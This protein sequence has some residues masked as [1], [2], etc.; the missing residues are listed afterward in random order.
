MVDWN[1]STVAIPA[2]LTQG[3]D[4]ST[5]VVELDSAVGYPPTPFTVVLSPR[6]ATE[7]VVTVTNTSGTT[8]TVNRGQ[9]GTAALPHSA[10]AGVEHKVTARDHQWSRD[11][12]QAS[13]GVHGISSGSVVGTSASQTLSNKNISGSNNS[14]TNIAQSSVNGLPAIQTI[15]NRLTG[16]GRSEGWRRMLKNTGNYGGG[17]G[18]VRVTAW[19]DSGLSPGSAG[20]FTY[21]IDE[22]GSVRLSTANSGPGPSMVSAFAQINGVVNS[23]NTGILYIRI[24][25][26]RPGGGTYTMITNRYQKFNTGTFDANV[27]ASITGVRM[28]P[29]DYMY[30]DIRHTFGG[31]LGLGDGAGASNRFEM[32]VTRPLS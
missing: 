11:H 19:I 28:N 18:W 12:E 22:P 31:T 16:D 5:G 24:T 30:V 25:R 7:E 21:G 17:G 8:W 2:V 29:G 14:L 15:T 20:G 26:V 1:Y 9:D 23:G 27:N 6:T 13:T 10:G 4:G 3:I 32:S